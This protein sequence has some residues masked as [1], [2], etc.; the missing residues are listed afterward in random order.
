MSYYNYQNFNMMNNGWGGLLQQGLGMLGGNSYG[1]MSMNGSIFG[2]NNFFTN[3]FGEPNYNAMAGFGVANALT[4]VLGMTISSIKAEK[5]EAKQ[6]NVDAETR[7][8]EID[9]EIGKKT[10]TINTK[11]GEKDNL[12]SSI[13]TLTNEIKELEGQ[14]VNL[15]DLERAWNDAYKTDPNSPET[16][17]AKNAYNNAKTKNENID[18]QIKEKNE[19]IEDIQKNQIP[20][21]D[22]AINELDSKIN[23]LKQ[24]KAKLEEQVTKAKLAKAQGKKY[25]ATKQEDFN[26]KWENGEP[27]TGVEFTSGDMRFAIGQFS[28]AVNDADKK[29]CAQKIDTIYRYFLNNDR[30]SI[31]SHFKFAA[32]KAQKYLKA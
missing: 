17:K 18:K 19:K 20:A 14:K 4:G 25:Q 7:I 29:A 6:A 16:T 23:E 24:E 11:N 28:D 26:A 8:G 15:I 5:A 13:T 12:N 3:C 1:M 32:E 21:C 31:T 22:K 30:N 9:K 10:E 2:G 27:K